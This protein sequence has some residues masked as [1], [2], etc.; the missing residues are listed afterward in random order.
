MILLENIVSLDEPSKV[1]KGDVIVCVR[2]NIKNIYIIDEIF[3]Q[4]RAAYMYDEEQYTVK[5]YND[6]ELQQQIFQLQEDL[7]V[8]QLALAELLDYQSKEELPVQLNTI[9]PQYSAISQ[10]Y[11]GMINRGI[12]TIEAVPS[13][14]REET[15]AVLLLL[16]NEED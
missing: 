5:E 6:M 4:K 8:T 2:K 14:W 11:A 3:K 1:Q 13:R 15:K 10:M 16:E 7:K 12:Y 9:Y